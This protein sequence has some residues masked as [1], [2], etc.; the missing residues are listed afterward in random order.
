[1]QTRTILSANGLSC[2]TVLAAGLIFS[3]CKESPKQIEEKAPE[4]GTYAYDA[5]F[6][7]KHT[8]GVVELYDSSTGARVLLS[9]QY[10]GRVMTSSAKGDSGTSYGWINYD[11]IASHQWKKQ[12]NPVGGEERFWLGPEGGQYS[13]YFAPKDSFLIKNW[14]VPPIIDTVTYDVI[15]SEP[16]VAGFR[17]EGSVTNYSGTKF[18][19]RITRRIFMLGKDTIESR[20]KTKVPDDVNVVGYLTDNVVANNGKDKWTKEKGLL[21]I[22]LLG[23]MTPTEN[24]V[25]IIPFRPLAKAKEKITTNYFGEIPADR[26]VIKDSVLFFRC[27][28]LY[29][30]KLGVSPAIAK[31]FAA[32]FDFKKNILTITNFSVIDWRPY[33]NSKW[34]IQK[35]PFKGDAMN[36]YNDGP[37]AGGLQLGPFYELESSSSVLDNMDE[38][39]QAVHRQTTVH[40]EGPFESLNAIAKDVL[41]VDLNDAR[42]VLSR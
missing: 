17:T 40:F 26:L 2:A 8:K 24:T 23:M 12:F 34:E 42:V 38:N 3:A 22:W 13:I 11:L 30:S 41:G 36:S 37:L 35:E 4:K 33:V 25:V 27:D 1:M 10:Q 14:Q 39:F 32:S 29:R 20:F 9:A 21:S 15:E 31:D 6:L 28:G 19:L 7:K 18:D 5:E 16:T